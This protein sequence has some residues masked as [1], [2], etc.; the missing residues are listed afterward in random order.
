M[1]KINS[2]FNTAFISEPGAKLENNDYFAFVELDD[3]ACYVLADGITDASGTGAA[4]LAVETILT[5]FQEN[6]TLKKKEILRWLHRAN[7]TLLNAYHYNKLKASVI[8]IV[9]DYESIRYINSGNVRFGLFRNGF[10]LARSSDMSL[11]KQ[12][13]DE[14]LMGDDILARHVERN[15]LSS[16]LGQD[17]GFVP[18]ISEPIKLQDGDIM[19]VYTKGIWENLDEMTM[20]EMFK[21]ASEKPQDLLD[22]AEDLILSA[23]PEDLD[24]YSMA[25]VYAN[26]IFKDPRRDERRRFWRRVAII[27]LIVLIIIGII[28]GIW[29]YYKN[30]KI[31][32]MNDHVGQTVTYLKHSNFKMAKVECGKAMELAEDLEDKDTQRILTTYGDLIE[33]VKGADELYTTQSYSEAYMAYS[34][35]LDITRDCDG[36]GKAYISRRMMETEKHIDCANLIA[37]GNE[38]MRNGKLEKAESAFLEAQTKAMVAGNMDDQQVASNALMQVAALMAQKDKED[39]EKARQDKV[40]AVN[41][42]LA[43][44]EAEMEAGELDGAEQKLRQAQMMANQARD[45]ASKQLVM[46]DMQQLTAKRGELSKQN[47]VDL[48]LADQLM[49]K[50][51][52][53]L[54]AADIDSAYM[55]YNAA[56]DKY[57]QLNDEVGFSVVSMKIRTIAPTMAD[58]ARLND[59]I[60]DTENQFREAMQAKDYNLT[61]QLGVKL[62]GMYQNVGNEAK[63]REINS[64]LDKID[65][66]KA[67]QDILNNGKR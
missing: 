19:T 29:T 48:N 7:D 52:L 61:K 49:Q 50:G 26:R 1:K 57:L 54:L 46:A 56:L 6:P 11:G 45:D 32:S 31:E 53:A 33:K 3:F 8:V 41:S 4:K 13:V 25:V 59:G 14:H 10:L 36:V 2:E 42:L 62:R 51:D 66:D 37:L 5:S 63:V 35:A 47:A 20:Q 17:D 16:Y 15:N 34:D 39:A 28:F 21:E 24:N 12:I 67:I 43:L 38:Q 60:D 22:E 9:S 30:K 23:Q 27:T 44:A 18:F 65:T 64:L 58:Q 40:D 55:M